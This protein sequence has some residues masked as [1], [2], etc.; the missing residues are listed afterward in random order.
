MRPAKT[1]TMMTTDGVKNMSDFDILNEQ[2][3]AQILNIYTFEISY[4]DAENEEF[5]IFKTEEGHY[6][7]WPLFCK[8]KRTSRFKFEQICRM[9]EDFDTENDQRKFTIN[10]WF[11]YDEFM[12]HYYN[13][14]GA[15]S[16][17]AYIQSF[18][19][20]S[21]RRFAEKQGVLPPQV[22]QWLQ[23]DTVVVNNKLYSFRR[24]LET[25]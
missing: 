10:G 18:F 16:L 21:Q 12:N 22:T 11:S 8:P 4:T 6:Y 25:S 24:D 13:V 9:A 17:E 14:N 19:G 3:N 2:I 20:G 23:K 1:W 7:V 15:L 5:R